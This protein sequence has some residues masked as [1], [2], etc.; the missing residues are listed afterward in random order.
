MLRECRGRQAVLSVRVLCDMR[1]RSEMAES[2]GLLADLPSGVRKSETE[3]ARYGIS[4][5][6][7]MKRDPQFKDWD[8]ES[9]IM[10]ITMI[11]WET[12][13]KAA[14]RAMLREFPAT[15]LEKCRGT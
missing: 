5:W 12:G 3:Y 13:F 4:L 2:I 14:L 9:L 1:V 8:D 6:R 10:A 11:A 15:P 7:H